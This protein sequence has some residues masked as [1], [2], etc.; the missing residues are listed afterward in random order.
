MWPLKSSEV[1]SRNSRFSSSTSDLGFCFL[2][3]K[4]WRSFHLALLYAFGRQGAWTSCAHRQKGHDPPGAG[5]GP[6]ASPTGQGCSGV[7]WYPAKGLPCALG[8]HPD[9]GVHIP[10][11]RLSSV[12][13][14]KKA[15]VS[16]SSA[17]TGDK[18][19]ISFL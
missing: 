15:R 10:A 13:L 3:A 7:S 16:N 19:S 17:V 9:V 1:D 4:G 18:T 11:L 14:G 6:P 5:A 12:T 8:V 2:S